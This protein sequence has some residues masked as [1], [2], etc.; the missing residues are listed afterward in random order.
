[1]SPYHEV[2]PWIWLGMAGHFPFR[3]GAPAI[4]KGLLAFLAACTPCNFGLW[5][6]SIEAKVHES[7][8]QHKSGGIPLHSRQEQ[9]LAAPE[10]E[11]VMRLRTV[12]RETK[13]IARRWAILPTH[14]RNCSYD[15]LG[16][17]MP[18]PVP[19]R[20]PGYFLGSP[21]REGLD[22][23]SLWDLERFGARMAEM[24]NMRCGEP[25]CLHSGCWD[26]LDVRRGNGTR[27][28]HGT[29]TTPISPSPGRE[30]G[31]FPRDPL[32]PIGHALRVPEGA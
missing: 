32:Q 12:Y 1:M 8:A 14:I 7:S 22:P 31:N 28:A 30:R 27:S 4:C 9:Y 29:D 15:V 17:R 3:K 10:A 23:R 11:V 13:Q 20:E 16:L 25:H 26:G 5:V 18:P 21:S 6:L 2:R 19:T 24:N